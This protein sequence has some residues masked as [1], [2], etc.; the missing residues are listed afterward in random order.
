M[1]FTVNDVSVE[2]ARLPLFRYLFIQGADGT[3]RA[4]EAARCEEESGLGARG[5]RLVL[6]H[7]CACCVVAEYGVHSR[8]ACVD[9]PASTALRRLPGM[10]DS[11]D[12]RLNFGDHGG[13]G[14]SQ[15]CPI[16][17]R[18]SAAPTTVNGS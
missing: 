13:R 5:S 1:S 14:K 12:V 18:R 7:P 11:D 8:L 15:L 10:G 6:K 3:L 4:D 9:C 2:R 17:G 16:G